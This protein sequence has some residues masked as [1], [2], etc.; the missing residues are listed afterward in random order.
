[1]DQV[2]LVRAQRKML[3][4]ERYVA[5]AKLR[6]STQQISHAEVQLQAAA[7]QEEYE[8]ADQLGQVIVA[9]DCEKS[10]VSALLDAVTGKLS[11]LESQK[12]V[13]SIRRDVH[14]STHVDELHPGHVV[15]SQ[16]VMKV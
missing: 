7:T 11:E 16:V 4:E 14:I 12:N 15:Q 10:E 6:L 3:L 1:M 5:I 8:L 13:A 2:A 9:H